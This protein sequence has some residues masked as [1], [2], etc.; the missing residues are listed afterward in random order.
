[1]YR[2]HASETCHPRTR[3][4]RHRTRATPRSPLDE[5]RS[6]TRHSSRSASKRQ[7]SA[8]QTVPH[9]QTCQ[10][11]PPWLL[12]RLAVVVVGGFWVTPQ[13]Q[14]P[15]QTP[16]ASSTS[17]AI[18]ATIAT[19]RHPNGQVHLSPWSPGQLSNCVACEGTGTLHISATLDCSTPSNDAV[20][21]AG[22]GGRLFLPVCSSP[23]RAGWPPAYLSPV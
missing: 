19:S 4:P 11:S 21:S 10:T 23:T 18:P 13:Y 9:L 20:L 3:F 5:S 1:M 22:N 12:H 6:N 15:R 16:P 17:L 14:D 2:C 7:R 8:L